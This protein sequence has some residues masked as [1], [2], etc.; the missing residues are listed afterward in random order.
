MEIYYEKQMEIEQSMKDLQG[1]FVTCTTLAMPDLYAW[2]I[3][4]KYVETFNK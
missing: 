1:F 3:N 4:K 2:T